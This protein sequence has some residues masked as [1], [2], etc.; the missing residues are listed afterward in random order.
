MFSV[1]PKFKGS[2]LLCQRL[3]R[4]YAGICHTRTSGG[5][6]EESDGIS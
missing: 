6:N 4:L 3:R 2:D 5:H 1:L